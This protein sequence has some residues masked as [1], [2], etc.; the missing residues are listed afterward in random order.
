MKLLAFVLILSFATIGR[1]AVPNAEQDLEKLARQNPKLYLPKLCD[2]VTQEM[3]EI[4]A[5]QLSLATPAGKRALEES[6]KAWLH[7]LDADGRLQ[8]A[9]ASGSG[10]VVYT[11]ER[12]IYQIRLRSYQLQTPFEQGWPRIKR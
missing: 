2:K 9:A 7:F 1:A 6:Q 4:Y 8:E 5:K 11:W 10:A 3:G 12:K